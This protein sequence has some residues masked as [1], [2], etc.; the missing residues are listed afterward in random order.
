MG[1][2]KILYLNIGSSLEQ[3]RLSASSA[4]RF[5]PDADIVVYTDSSELDLTAQGIEFDHYH[6]WDY[7][8]SQTRVVIGSAAF[9]KL[10]AQKS[11]VI[12]DSL[13]KYKS[14]TLYV[15]TD[16]VFTSPISASLRICFVIKPLWI[17]TDSHWGTKGNPSIGVCTGIIAI[18][19]EPLVLQFLAKWHSSH[20]E[21]I[22]SENYIH[23]QSVF[24]LIYRSEEKLY[25]LTGI[26]PVTFAMPGWMYPSIQHFNRFKNGVVM[27]PMFHCN[28]VL[29]DDEKIKRMTRVMQMWEFNQTWSGFLGNLIH[30]VIISYK[31]HRPSYRSLIRGKKL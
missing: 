25:G 27:P 3:L 5:N 11:A 12:L 18:K 15:D 20:L 14:P 23:D 4:R 6:H 24:D 13:R 16:V 8:Q 28:F 2:L 7:E 29:H 17:S 22:K 26:F 21:H 30:L 31:N 10:T 9:A 1:N 19:P